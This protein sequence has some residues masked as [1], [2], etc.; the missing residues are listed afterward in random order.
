MGW[1]GARVMGEREERNEGEF[2]LTK[3]ELEVGLFNV[4]QCFTVTE[5]LVKNSK[6]NQWSYIEKC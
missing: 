4:F 3:E 1:H 5:L 6:A 2:K